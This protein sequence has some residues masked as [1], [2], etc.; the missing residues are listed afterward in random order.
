M[1]VVTP[2]DP[3]TEETVF[4]VLVAEVTLSAERSLFK[5]STS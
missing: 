5:I 1:S 3:V 4:P 2:K